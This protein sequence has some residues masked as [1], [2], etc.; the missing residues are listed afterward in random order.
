MGRYAATGPA[1]RKRRSINT[2]LVA[3]LLGVALVVLVVDQVT[4]ILA[5][6]LLSETRA[7]PLIGDFISL[8]LT[9]NPGA[10]LS[11]ASGA[12]VVFTIIALVVVLVVVRI[13]GRIGSR[14]WSICLGLLLGGAIG[15]LIDRLFR[16]PGF[17]VGHVVDFINYNGWFIGNVAD[18]AIVLAAVGIALLAIFG[19]ET[20]G[21]RITSTRAEKRASAAAEDADESDADEPAATAGEVAD[22]PETAETVDA[23]GGASE[24]G[25]E[26]SPAPEDGVRHDG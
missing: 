13:A 22:A 15:N 9:Y 7:V 16:E 26:D 2:P 4:K 6:E 19:I 14:W 23:G 25:A 1:V 20:D 21:T 5:V 3:L 17:A 12:T 18:I 11:F 10:A 24:P 8:Q